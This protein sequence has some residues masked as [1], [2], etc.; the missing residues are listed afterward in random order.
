MGK[1]E[2]PESKRSLRHRLTQ[3]ALHPA[4]HIASLVAL[5]MAALLVI[6]LVEKTP[7]LAL[8]H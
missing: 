4:V 7:L 8:I 2:A 5:H 3:R 6:G 1:H